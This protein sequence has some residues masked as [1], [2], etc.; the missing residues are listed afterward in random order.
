MSHQGE[1]GDMWHIHFNG[2]CRF[3]SNLNCLNNNSGIQ[4]H[5]HN[6]SG[7]YV[8]NCRNNWNNDSTPT[9]RGHALDLKGAG[10]RMLVSPGKE[11]MNMAT[12]KEHGG[13]W[14]TCIPASVEERR[15]TRSQI[16]TQEMQLGNVDAMS[17]KCYVC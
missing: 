4:K 13:K 15:T 11:E 10:E 2:L 7:E 16:N 14:W 8:K 6:N 9:D 5:Q 12:L 17:V 1:T 3:L